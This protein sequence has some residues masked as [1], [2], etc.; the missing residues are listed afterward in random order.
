MLSV[1]LQGALRHGR[2]VR[3]AEE[4]A[5]AAAAEAA[6]PVLMEFDAALRAWERQ[7]ALLP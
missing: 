6:K 7:S 1:R 5:E 2:W 3:A 4:E